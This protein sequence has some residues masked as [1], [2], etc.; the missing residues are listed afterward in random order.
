MDVLVAQ[1][2]VWLLLAAL[3]GGGAGW[4]V[5]GAGRSDGAALAEAQRRVADLERQ[6]ATTRGARPLGTAAADA[7]TAHLADATDGS[8]ADTDAPPAR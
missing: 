8:L 1:I 6:L 7:R 3:L 5:R 2:A 4:L